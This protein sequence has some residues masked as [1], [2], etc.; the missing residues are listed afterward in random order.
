MSFVVDDRPHRSEPLVDDPDFLA[1]LDALDQHLAS[2]TGRRKEEA[3]P[4]SSEASAPAAFHERPF[5]PRPLLDLFPLARAEAPATTAPRTALGPAARQTDSARGG[6]LGY[7]S[8]YGLTT[9]PFGAAPDPEFLYHSASHERAAQEMLSAVRRR[10]RLVV[11]TGPAG[12]G[13]TIVCQ[14][15]A[16][17][18]DRRTLVSFATGPFSG[19]E[20]LL[21]TILVDFG[22]ISREDVSTEPVARMERAGLMAA[23]REFL[24]TLAPLEAFA[25]VIIDG[26][27]RLPPDV[28]DAVRA[29]SDLEQGERLLQIVLVGRPFPRKRLR[30]PALGRLVGRAAVRCTLGPLEEGEVGGYVAHRLS[31]AGTNLRVDFDDEAVARVHELSGGVPGLVNV[32]CDRALADGSKAAA[33]AIDRAL[34]DRTAREL[35]IEPPESPVVSFVRVTA[36]V[37]AFVLLVMAGAAGAARLFRTRLAHDQA[38]AAHKTR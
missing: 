1:S 20:D 31:V 30:L 37:L 21:K 14:A 13:K 6:A 34:V 29:L 5:A 26:A 18:L 22:V 23:V 27:D 8:F 7:A 33:S 36:A 11:L 15:V 35:G 28:L 38:P 25:V 4:A 2:G 24:A 3:A 9:S 32:I 10:E 16:E 17:E 12:V 19:A